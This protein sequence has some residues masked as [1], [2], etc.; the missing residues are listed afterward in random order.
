[1][2]EGETR[3]VEIEGLGDQGDGISRVE[4]GFILIVPDTEP[5]ER[6][7]VTVTAVH[8]SLAFAA[9]TERLD[10]YE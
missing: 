8:D 6:V 7:K 3:I 1:M 4:N 5:T 9:V 2:R 10:Y